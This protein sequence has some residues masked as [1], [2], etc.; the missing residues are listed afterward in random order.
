MASSTARTPTY[1][2]TPH[3]NI[4]AAGGALTLGTVVKDL[5]ELAP[6]NKEDD[7]RELGF[8]AKVAGQIG[9]SGYIN[10]SG[11]QNNEE[12]FSCDNIE[13]IYFDPTDEWVA[14][15]LDKKPVRDYMESSWY[16]REVYIIKGLKVAKSFTF[17]SAALVA[18]EIKGDIKE[19]IQ[20]LDFQSTDI[21]VGFRVKKCRYKKKHLFFGELKLDNELYIRGAQSLS[22]EPPPREPVEREPIQVIK[23][24]LAQQGAEE[25][26]RP[27]AALQRETVEEAVSLSRERTKRAGHV[28]H[29]G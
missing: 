6:L 27:A 21:V 17:G 4:A 2:V 12:T 25:K 29:Q 10:L 24:H 22:L 11:E 16:G 23:V 14:K 5:L 7:D 20:T 9:I 13:T 18:G 15:C 8:W 1:H 19:K 26:A 28:A 3:F